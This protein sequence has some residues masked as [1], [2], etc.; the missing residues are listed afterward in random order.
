[1]LA[2]G[3]LA[4]FGARDYDH[5]IAE[6]LFDAWSGKHKGEDLRKNLKAKVRVYKEAEKAKQSECP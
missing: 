2:R 6:Q 3:G 1:M 5:A 4:S